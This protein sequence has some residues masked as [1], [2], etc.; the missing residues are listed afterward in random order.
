MFRDHEI[1]LINLAVKL[2]GLPLRT[3]DRKLRVLGIR[4]RKNP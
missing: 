4:E 2:L 3:L 1:A